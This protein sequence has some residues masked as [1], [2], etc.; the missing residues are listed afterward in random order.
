[1]GYAEEKVDQEAGSRI[2]RLRRFPQIEEGSGAT[3][4]TRSVHDSQNLRQSA[5]FL[6]WYAWEDHGLS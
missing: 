1:M 4:R 5:D 6:L 3:G 2:R